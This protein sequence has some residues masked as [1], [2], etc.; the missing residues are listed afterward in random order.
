MGCLAVMVERRSTPFA[1]THYV[2]NRMA[3][4]PQRLL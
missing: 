4:I 2:Q 1:F 3:S